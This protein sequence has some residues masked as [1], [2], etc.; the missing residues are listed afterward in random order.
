VQSRQPFLVLLISLRCIVRLRVWHKPW[1]DGVMG[2]QTK[3]AKLAGT[4][5]SQVRNIT[6]IQAK[7]DRISNGV[8]GDQHKLSIFIH[9]SDGSWYILIPSWFSDDREYS[10]I[11]GSHQVFSPEIEPKITSS[12][13]TT[14]VAHL[15]LAPS[16]DPLLLKTTASA[17]WAFAA[18]CCDPSEIASFGAISLRAWPT[19]HLHPDTA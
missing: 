8:P 16:K 9:E 13:L 15:S 4:G 17:S 3:K 14:V 18:P 10:S 2:R 5:N 6:S 1:R 7:I 12:L 19:T 11:L